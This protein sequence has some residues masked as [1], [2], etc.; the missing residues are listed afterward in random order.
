MTVMRV[1]RVG[2]W[3]SV[4]YHHLLDCSHIEVRR[5]C[6]KVGDKIACTRCQDVLE[7]RN[8]LAEV[9]PASQAFHSDEDVAAEMTQEARIRA[10]VAAMLG[11][12][13]DTV[14]VALLP[15][16]RITIFLSPAEVTRLSGT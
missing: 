8:A 16:R 15:T 11:V 3:G 6:A 5:R 9:A 4:S 1:D 12:P 14:D 13:A 7:R 2:A 10:N